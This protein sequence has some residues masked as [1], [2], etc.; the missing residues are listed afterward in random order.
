MI[1]YYLKLSKAMRT[2]SIFIFTSILFIS[3]CKKDTSDIHNGYYNKMHFERWGGGQKDFDVFMTE[4]EDLLTV[5]VSKISYAETKVQIVLHRDAKNSSAFSAFHDAMNNK[6]Q[7]T[8]DYKPF[9]EGPI[10]ENTI[11]TG[12]GTVFTFF[13][14]GN[15]I[16]VT[17]A[18]L[19]DSLAMLEDLVDKELGIVYTLQ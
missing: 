13:G 6:I 16:E 4:N 18:G 8:G 1:I 5:N 2:F 14:N 19:R 12:T 10:D 11:L 7:L 9:V 15:E 17:N 3:G